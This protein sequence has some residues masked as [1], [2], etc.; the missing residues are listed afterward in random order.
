[1]LQ[2]TLMDSDVLSLLCCPLILDAVSSI[3]QKSLVTLSH[4]I[5]SDTA[6]ATEVTRSG[7]LDSLVL[8]LVHN[9]PIVRAAAFQALEGLASTSEECARQVVDAGNANLYLFQMCATP[10]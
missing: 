9:A 2:N 1:M 4:L 6:V 7:V 8:S 5:S 3:R 10:K